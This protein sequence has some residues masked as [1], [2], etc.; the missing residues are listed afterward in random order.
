MF[1]KIIILLFIF[2]NH[3]LCGLQKWPLQ[4]PWDIFSNLMSDPLKNSS[5]RV[6][7]ICVWKD[8]SHQKKNQKSIW[9]G[10]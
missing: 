3:A 7:R 4:N 1:L 10:G 9:C 5:G 6:A 8:F 2:E